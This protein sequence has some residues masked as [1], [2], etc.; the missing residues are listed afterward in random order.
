VCAGSRKDRLGARHFA[1]TVCRFPGR[2]A[3]RGSGGPFPGQAFPGAPGGRDFASYCR[4]G[5][6]R[7]GRAP[8]I[9]GRGMPG[10]DVAPAVT[11]CAARGARQ[12]KYP[13]A[14][15]SGLRQSESGDACDATF[16]APFR[17]EEM[18]W[19]TASRGAGED[20]GWLGSLFVLK[21]GR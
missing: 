21:Q 16:C 10:P 20:L 7:A 19:D 8:A 2:A 6:S 12:A 18:G 5:P 17:T 3:G 4:A 9:A 1:L 13:P 15:H 14:A 11:L